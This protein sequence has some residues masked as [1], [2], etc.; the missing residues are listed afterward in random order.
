M[1]ASFDEGAKLL[2]LAGI[3]DIPLLP[4]SDREIA[5]RNEL[6]NSPGADFIIEEAM[7]EDS[8]PL[9]VCMLGCATDI[10][11]A[12]LKKPEIADKLT[13]I[14]IGG[15]N[16]PQGSREFNLIQDVEA[17]RILFESPVQVWQIPEGVYKTMEISLMELVSRVRPCGELGNYLCQQMLDLNDTL[18]SRPGDFPAGETWALG[19]NPTVSVLIQS[20]LRINWHTEKAPAF[21]DDGT[22]VPN[23]NGKEIRVYDNV[24]VRMTMEDMFWKLS[25]CYRD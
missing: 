3:D 7:K 16:Y 10:A 9:Y 4:G 11:I 25:T 19:D 17:A 18:C 21:L 6:P 20:P 2:K 15:G 8:H 1:Q 14:W 13:V 5:D 23:E 12:L 22:Y 24:D